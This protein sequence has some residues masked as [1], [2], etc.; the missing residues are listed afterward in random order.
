MQESQAETAQGQES[1]SETLQSQESQAESAQGQTEQAETAQ[2]QEQT[3]APETAAQ[4]ETQD[5]A[6]ETEADTRPDT[7]TV[8]AGDTLQKI[9]I[10]VY[11]NDSMVEELCEKNNIDNPDYLFAGQ[12]L[13]LP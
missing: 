1:Q 8:Q 3:E 2:S 4:P 13:Q 6:G 11:G 12:V 7:Y 5:N 10:A 9:S